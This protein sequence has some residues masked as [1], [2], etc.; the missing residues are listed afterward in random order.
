MERL[1]HGAEHRFQPGRLGAGKTQ[2]NRHLPL[3]EIEQQPCRCCRAE[4]AKGR[5]PVEAALIMRAHHQR[6]DEAGRLI[7]GDV[8][9]QHVDSR[10]AGR[11]GNR[12]HRRQDCGCGMTYQRMNIVVVERMRGRAIDQCGIGRRATQIEADDR[13]RSLRR[14]CDL[15]TQNAGNRLAGTRERNT[16]PIQNAL[17]GHRQRRGIELGGTIADDMTGK[18]RCQVFMFTP[19]PLVVVELDL[20]SNLRQNRPAGSP[21]QLPTGEISCRKPFI[22]GE[23]HVCRYAS[24]H[25][26]SSP[27]P[28]HRGRDRKE[29]RDRPRTRRGAT[30]AACRER[31]SAS[32]TPTRAFPCRPRP[33]TSSS[34]FPAAAR[35]T[36]SRGS[37]S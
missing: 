22:K 17:F 3:V 27:F 10:T 9:T 4:R 21:E 32:T 29:G 2:R 12:Q 11:L 15:L 8:G 33:A 16:I 20:N 36:I 24:R 1:C 23:R 13:R 6:A 18:P 7:A 28:Q 37:S 31:R 5:G 19:C 35:C 30:G 14:G 26:P 25:R 34:I